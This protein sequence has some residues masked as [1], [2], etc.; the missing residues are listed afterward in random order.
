M[1]TI[2]SSGVGQNLVTVLGSADQRRAGIR[3]GSYNGVWLQLYVATENCTPEDGTHD[4][5]V[6]KNLAL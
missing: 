2:G 3:G 6:D 4:A 1:P 5:A